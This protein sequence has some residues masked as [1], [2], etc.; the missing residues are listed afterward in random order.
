[1]KNRPA[2]RAAVAKVAELLGAEPAN[3]VWG[4]EKSIFSLCQCPF[5]GESWNVFPDAALQAALGKKCPCELH[6]S[7]SFPSL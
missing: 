7:V 3:M 2:F 5:Q 1:M 6:Q 4:W